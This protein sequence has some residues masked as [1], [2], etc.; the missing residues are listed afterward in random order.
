MD[1]PASQPDSTIRRVEIE[2]I[3]R[4]AIRARMGQGAATAA[5]TLVVD[6]SARHCHVCREDLDVLF[7]KGHELTVFRDLY[8]PGNFAATEMVTI[9]GPRSRLISNLRILG[10]LRSRSQ[11]ELAFTDAIMLGIDAPI[12]LSGDIDGTPGCFLMGPKG[13]VELK[14]GVIRAAI[15]VHMNPDEAEYF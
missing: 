12:R 13:M 11:V 14:E 1:M 5:P 15:H 7:G 2:E 8:Q 10:P 4:Q 6:A 3:V 9:I